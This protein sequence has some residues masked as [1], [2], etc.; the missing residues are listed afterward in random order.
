MLEPALPV[1]LLDG[2]QQPRHLLSEAAQAVGA[3]V[4]H[5]PK[6]PLVSV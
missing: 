4:L 2:G 1:G 6:V 3:T 5:G